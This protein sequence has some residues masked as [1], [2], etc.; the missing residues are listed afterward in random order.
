MQPVSGT[1]LTL[2]PLASQGHLAQRLSPYLAPIFESTCAQATHVA[3]AV[4]GGADSMALALLL[5]QWCHHHQ[6]RLTALTVDHQLRPE[7]ASEASQVAQWMAQHGIAHHILTTQADTT[8]RNVQS[9]ARELRYRALTTWC[10]RH[11]ASHL[12][13]AHHADD[14]AET[15]M[16][17]RH[18]GTTAAS[19]AGM[20]LVTDREGIQ[21]IRP[22]LGLRKPM[23]MDYLNGQRQPWL[24]DPTNRNEQYARNRLRATLSD[25]DIKKL[26]HHAQRMGEARYQ[27]DEARNQWLGEHVA[28]LHDQLTF[29]LPA[30][31]RL[32]AIQASD[33]LGFLIRTVGNKTFRPR[34]HESQRLAD[35]LRQ[36]SH[37]KATLGHCVIRWADTRVQITPEKS[38]ALLLE[39]TANTPHIHRPNMPKAL[40]NAP[41]WWFN[42]ALFQ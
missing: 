2:A 33:V 10:R 14:Q 37:G 34:A 38:R 31:R 30:W 6:R 16:L 4:S 35:A 25:A 20:A 32:E 28:C 12:A 40:G 18:R 7:S 26:W 41:F 8:I 29:S 21:I 1:P 11:D 23:L 3:I 36:T 27:E 15:V 9:R 39:S 22:L 24:E 17:Q 13:V 5:Q 19:H 42:Y